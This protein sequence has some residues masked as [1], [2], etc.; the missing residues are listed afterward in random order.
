MTTNPRRKL[1][2]FGQ[3]RWLDYVR[4]QMITS[5]DLRSRIGADASWRPNAGP[6]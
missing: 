4:R 1:E 3:S 6:R 2:E 5:G